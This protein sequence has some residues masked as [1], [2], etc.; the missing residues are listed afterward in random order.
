MS[1]IDEILASGRYTDRP[2]REWA[3]LGRA[4]VLVDPGYWAGWAMS[5]SLGVQEMRL[6][7]ERDQHRVECLGLWECANNPVPVV[8]FENGAYWGRTC[9]LNARAWSL[10]LQLRRGHGRCACTGGEVMIVL[11][12]AAALIPAAVWAAIVLEPH[13]GV[14]GDEKTAQR[15]TQG[16]RRNLKHRQFRDRTSDNLTKR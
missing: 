3:E 10:V 11:I 7:I 6:L 2:G 14:M 5:E 15:G 8:H 1:T 13:G 9:T 4:W 12:I 16:L